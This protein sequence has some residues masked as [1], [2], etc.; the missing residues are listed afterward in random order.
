M[1][2]DQLTIEEKKLLFA[3]KTR[4]V[5]VKTNKKFIYSNLQCRLCNSLEEDES[6]I[7]VMKCSKIISDDSLKEQFGTISYSDIFGSMKQQISAVK[8]LR[9]IFKFW[10]IKK[11]TEKLSPS[12]HQAHLLQGQSASYSCTA[13]QTVDSTSPDDSNCILYDFG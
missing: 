13:A 2:C 10:K 7:H 12:G 8:I 3:L 9:K 11:K 5:D 6:E 4:S 1:I